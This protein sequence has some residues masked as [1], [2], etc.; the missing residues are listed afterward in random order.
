[1]SRSF[2]GTSF[3]RRPS[4]E[5]SP[6]VIDFQ[7]GDHAQRRRLPAARRPEQDHELAVRHV[8][9]HRVHGER[10]ARRVALREAIEGHRGHRYFTAPAVIPWI[11]FSEKNA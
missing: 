6:E 8:E 1:M 7:A 3:T 11:S 5:S 9:R 10:V 4:I 2:A